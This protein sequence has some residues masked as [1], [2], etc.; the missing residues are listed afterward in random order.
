LYIF[1]IPKCELFKLGAMNEIEKPVHLLVSEC[2]FK[3][4]LH[5]F[6]V[7]LSLEWVPQLRFDWWNYCGGA[8]TMSIILELKNLCWALTIGMILHL[9]AI[10]LKL[11]SR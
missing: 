1:A 4:K 9:D 11:G 6:K 3:N 7:D 10:L 2:C 8:K 5:N